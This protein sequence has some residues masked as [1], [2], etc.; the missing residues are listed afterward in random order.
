M[1]CTAL[2]LLAGPVDNAGAAINPE[3][4]QTLFGRLMVKYPVAKLLLG[5]QQPLDGARRHL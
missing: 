3:V 5:A 1:A 2:M 4:V